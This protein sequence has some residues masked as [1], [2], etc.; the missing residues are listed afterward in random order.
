MA[1]AISSKYRVT[2][3]GP[4]LVK[5]DKN[6]MKGVKK[7]LIKVGKDVTDEVQKRTPNK[8]GTLRRNIKEGKPTISKTNAE[9]TI[10][11]GSSHGGA[12]GVKTNSIGDVI[13]ALWIETGRRKGSAAM[14]KPKGGYKMFEKAEKEVTK[15]KN[16]KDMGKTIAKQLGGR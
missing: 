16:I 14:R 11:S 1:Q 3:K 7:A 12:T 2:V 13:Y 6:L 9:I 15:P 5:G 4:L 10:S 8:T